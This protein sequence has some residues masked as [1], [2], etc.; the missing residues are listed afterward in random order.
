MLA[1]EWG[2]INSSDRLR[3][4]AQEAAD[5]AKAALTK[6]T[7]AKAAAAQLQQRPNVVLGGTEFQEIVQEHHVVR[8][9]QG[10]MLPVDEHGV[11]VEERAADMTRRW[12]GGI[13]GDNH[14][15][16]PRPA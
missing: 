6:A 16:G 7:P 15:L 1:R 3:H 14:F 10:E 5:Q 4:P 12:W 8:F 11:V 2:R 13:F 9:G